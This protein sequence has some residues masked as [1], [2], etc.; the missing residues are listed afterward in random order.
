[1]PPPLVPEVSAGALDRRLRRVLQ[2]DSKGQH[3]VCQEIRQ[4]WEEGKK[5]KVFKMFAE[6][7]NND[8]T[9]FT[10]TYSI[11]KDQQREFELGVFFTFQ[12]EEELSDK[13]EKLC[14]K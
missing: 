8:P 5:Q 12:T 10:K 14:C 1:M 7:N 6:C 9:L 13:P 4:M 3:K 11:K 2:P